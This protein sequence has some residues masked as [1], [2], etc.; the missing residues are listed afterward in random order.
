MLVALTTFP[1]DGRKLKQF[2]QWLIR[3]WIAACINRINYVK[4]YYM[5][6]GVL[7]QE[8]EKILLIKLPKNHK[9]QFLAFCKKNHPYKIPE[10]LFFEPED[11]DKGYLEWVKACS[12]QK[13]KR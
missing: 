8:E 11:V 13:E 6:E 10:L 3:S 7:N 2:I 12:L 9:E 5:R 1:N 4:S